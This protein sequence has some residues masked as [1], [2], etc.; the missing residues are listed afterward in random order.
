MAIALVKVCF[1]RNSGRRTN[2]VHGVFLTQAQT[3]ASALR[4]PR[5]DRLEKPLDFIPKDYIPMNVR[6]N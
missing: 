2:M 4:A 6:L 3:F 5:S 1:R